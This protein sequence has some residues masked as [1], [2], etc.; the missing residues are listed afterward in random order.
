MGEMQDAQV[1]VSNLRSGEKRKPFLS[2]FHALWTHHF[3]LSP[4]VLEGVPARGGGR[5]RCWLPLQDNA[6]PRLL[7]GKGGMLRESPVFPGP[8]DDHTKWSKSD[9]ERHTSYDIT[10]TWNVKNERGTYTPMFMAA[11]FTIAKTWKPPK[12]PRTGEWI[13]EMWYIIYNGILL[14]H[15]KEGNNAICSN[16]DG[17]RDDHTQWSK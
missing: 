5:A 17:P 13:K 7:P 9:R 2:C 15:E 6:F 11:V 3:P 14:S 4:A 1:V 10:Y 8:G 16:T 12:C